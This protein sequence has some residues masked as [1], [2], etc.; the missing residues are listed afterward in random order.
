MRTRSGTPGPTRASAPSAKAVSW[1]RTWRSAPSF[2]RRGAPGVDGQVDRDRHDHPAQRDHQRQTLSRRRSTQLT[3][4]ELAARLQVATRKKN[5]ISPE[6]TQPCQLSA[7]P[8]VPDQ[9]H[10]HGAPRR[11]IPR[12]VN[13]GPGQRRQRGLPAG[14][15]RCPVSS[16][17]GTAEAASPVAAP[18]PC[19][20]KTARRRRPRFEVTPRFSRAPPPPTISEAGPDPQ[21]APN[22]ASQPANVAHASHR[23][24][25]L[26]CH[27]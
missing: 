15:P 21:S 9:D 25:A 4:V 27:R 7:S 13:V 26:D 24:L 12:R 16:T 11:R 20:A 19:A 10:Q 22:P 17:R 6:F 3:Q 5:A 2:G 14:P 23:K 1:W 8:L 18:T